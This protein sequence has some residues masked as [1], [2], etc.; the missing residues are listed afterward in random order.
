MKRYMVL[1][2]IKGALVT[3]PHN[4]ARFVSQKRVDRKNSNFADRY[5]P[6]TKAYP[7]HPHLAKA[8]SKGQLKLLATVMANSAEEALKE[9][10]A[11]QKK[12]DS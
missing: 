5:Q 2:G 9:S 10:K 3:D 4:E 12:G 6:E 1:Q 7:H 11:A 8:V